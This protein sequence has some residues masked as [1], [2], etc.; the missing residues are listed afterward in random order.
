MRVRRGVLVYHGQVVRL[1]VVGL[2]VLAGC[3]TVFGLTRDDA[4]PRDARTGDALDAPGDGALVHPCAARSPAPQFCFDFDDATFVGYERG[5]VFPVGPTATGVS[6]ERRP[7]GFTAPNALWLTAPNPGTAFI[8]RQD[9]TTALSHIEA[10]LRMRASTTS[11]LGAS[12]LLVQLSIADRGGACG[13]ELSI[14]AVTLALTYRIECGSDEMSTAVGFLDDTWKRVDLTFDRVTGRG[15]ASV[16]ES[17]SPALQIFGG[18]GK[19]PPSIIVG[20][21]GVQEA[22]LTAAFDDI[23]VVAQ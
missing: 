11:T 23:S 21:L 2:A 13:S 19:G 4:A 20:L 5:A 22:G 10:S 14:D 8:A 3:D 12:I 6:L 16:G 17:S 18:P 7:P 15:T 1:L 9:D